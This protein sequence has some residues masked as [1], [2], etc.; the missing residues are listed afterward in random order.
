[1]DGGSHGVPGP[2]RFRRIARGTAE[3]DAAFA[4]KFWP[5]GTMDVRLKGAYQTEG[6]FAAG[7]VFHSMPFTSSPA[8]SSSPTMPGTLAEI[9]K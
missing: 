1:M 7:D 4:L 6:R 3:D 9:A 2:V 5:G 8:A